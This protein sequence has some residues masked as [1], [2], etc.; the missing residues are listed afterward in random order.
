MFFVQ[1]GSRDASHIK[2][3]VNVQLITC[4]VQNFASCYNIPAA[5]FMVDFRISSLKS[6]VNSP[7]IT[8][9]CVTLPSVVFSDL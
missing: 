3:S 7:P 5:E 4:S 8:D 1:F 9:A 6:V 2:G